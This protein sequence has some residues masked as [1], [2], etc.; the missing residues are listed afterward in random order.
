MI[1]RVLLAV[2]VLVMGYAVYGALTDPAA[3]PVGQVVFLATVLGTHDLLVMPAAI[4]VGWL[5]S[6]LLPGWARGPV[7]AGLFTTAVLTTIALP[8][9]IGNGHPPDNPSALPLDYGRGLAIVVA[10]VWVVVGGLV[11]RRL[12][13]ARTQAAVGPVPRTSDRPAP[14]GAGG[15]TRRA[16]NLPVPPRTGRPSPRGASGPGPGGSGAEHADD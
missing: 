1:R 8:F 3:R 7:Q 6:R 14:R 9:L 11:L 10:A 16:A 12:V 13:M 2:G 5:L 4:G 15:S